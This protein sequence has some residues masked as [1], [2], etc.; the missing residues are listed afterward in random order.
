MCACVHVC[1]CAC[2]QVNVVWHEVKEGG[3]SSEGGMGGALHNNEGT[4][5][6]TTGSQ[7]ETEE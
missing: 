3:A 2:V 7:G 6:I 1:M 4:G 5:F